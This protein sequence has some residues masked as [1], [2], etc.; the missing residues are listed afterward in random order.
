MFSRRLC[1][2]A[3]GLVLL[4]S[5]PSPAVASIYSDFVLN[6]TAP[7]IYWNQDETSGTTANDLAPGGGTNNGTYTVAGG[8]S[9]T[10]GTAG[11][12]PADGFGNMD[13]ANAAPTVDHYGTTVYNSLNTT[14]GASISAYSVQ[15]WFNP[16]AL[17]DRPLSYVFTRANSADESGRRDAVY[18]GGTYGGIT[19]RVLA[20][21]R[22]NNASGL[23]SIRGTRTLW[24]NTW[25]HL[26]FVRD[27]SQPDVKAKVYLNGKLEITSPYVWWNGTSSDTGNYFYAANR[28]DYNIGMGVSGRYDEVAVWD[29]PLSD[30]EAWSLFATATG[31]KNYPAVVLS[32][33]PEAYWRLNETTGNNTAIDLSGHGHHFTYNDE[34]SRT[35]TGLDIGPQPL[36]YGGFESTNAAPR[37]I[38]S[39]NINQQDGFIGTA[40]GVLSGENDYSLEMWIRREQMND[41]PYQ[42]RGLYLMH[43]N[44]VGQP[45]A[46]GNAGDYLGIIPGDQPGEV[47]LFM[48]NGSGT[49]SVSFYGQSD[50]LEGVWYHLAMTRQGDLMSVYL[51]GQLEMQGTMPKRPGTVW[52]YGYWTFGNRLDLPANWQRF[53]GNIDEIA[54]YR[55]VLGQDVFYAHY[56]AAMVP[57]PA[58]WVLWVLGGLA[59]LGWRG[60]RIGNRATPGERVAP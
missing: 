31:Q 6:S 38:K 32:D 58:T 10:L 21:V 8:H 60:L 29:R 56:L 18:V 30:A 40:T 13:A 5:L 37:L 9:V 19:P 51:N 49:G 14:A 15:V 54:I 1:L 4:A 34:P 26:T 33:S 45:G 20:L 53:N 48:F 59:A 36:K 7:V 35:G 43:R 25:Y 11:P 3:S 17:L 55:G 57:E 50:L 22:G 46:T 23:P 41:P 16:S 52:T 27:D 42:S 24:E 2:L 12:R 44:D 39:S 28:P 47:N